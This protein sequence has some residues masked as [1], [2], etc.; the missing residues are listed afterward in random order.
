MVKIFTIDDIQNLRVL[1]KDHPNDFDLGGIVRF[2]YK[3]N[4][5]VKKTPND[6]DLGKEIRKII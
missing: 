3:S 1:S 6:F 4:E 2:L 5:I